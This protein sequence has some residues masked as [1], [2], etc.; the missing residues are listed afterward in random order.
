MAMIVVMIMIMIV[1]MVVAITIALLT[2]LSTLR[3]LHGLGSELLGQLCGV[4]SCHRCRKCF[5]CMR[6][7]KCLAQ[8]LARCVA[9]R[10]VTA[11]GFK[12]IN[13]VHHETPP[14]QR[15]PCNS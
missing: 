8:F 3:G 7:L 5:G 4:A 9:Q 2:G 14:L 13:R 12:Q 15:W 10:C 6:L 11:D 1:T